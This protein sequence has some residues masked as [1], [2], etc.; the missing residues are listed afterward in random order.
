MNVYVGWTG[1]PAS[2]ANLVNKVKRLKTDHPE[3]YNAFLQQS[4][5]AVNK[6]IKGMQTNEHTIFYEGVKENRLALSSLGKNSNVPIETEKLLLLSE[7]AE[8]FGGAGKLSGAG[9]GDCGLAFV[10]KNTNVKRLYDAWE[11]NGIV[12]LHI[13]IHPNGAQSIHV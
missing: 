2:T 5:R 11:E 6:I 12:P 8:R 3:Q 10:P 1:K 13:T 9:G 4:K 7:E